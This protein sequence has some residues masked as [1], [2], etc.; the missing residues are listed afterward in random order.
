ADG[1][2][3]QKI[4]GEVTT[5]FDGDG[6]PVVTVANAVSMVPYFYNVRDQLVRTIDM[7]GQPVTFDYDHNGLRIKKAGSAGETR[8]LY[9]TQATLLEYN[10]A[11]E[12]TIKYDYGFELLSLTDVDPATQARATQFYLYD[13]LGSTANLTNQAGSIQI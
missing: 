7:T 13:G 6:N 10:Q 2:R 9:D 3:T 11:G 12:T 8:Y 5:T 1:N 4:V